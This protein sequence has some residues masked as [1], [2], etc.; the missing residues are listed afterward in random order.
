VQFNG[1]GV[2]YHLVDLLPDDKIVVTR[3]D[4]SVA[5]FRVTR[6]EQF[7]KDQFPTDKVYG[8][9]DHAGLAADHLRWPQRRDGQ[10]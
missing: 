7:S 9:I 10:L 1:P 2:F 4:G 6:V 5:V 8:N 3:R